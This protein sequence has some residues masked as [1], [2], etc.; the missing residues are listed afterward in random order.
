MYYDNNCYVVLVL[1]YVELHDMK[2]LSLLKARVR[3]TSSRF[4]EV[5]ESEDSNRNDYFNA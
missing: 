2:I 3:K 4:Y 1:S 5:C